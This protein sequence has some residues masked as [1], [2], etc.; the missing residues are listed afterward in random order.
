GAAAAEGRAF[1][2]Y[3]AVVLIVAAR[4][5]VAVGGTRFGARMLLP[6]AA[7][8]GALPRPVEFGT[9]F[10]GTVEFRP[11]AKRAVAFWTILA[12]TRETRTLGAAAVL[13]RLVEARF[14]KAGLVEIARA[15]ARGARIAPGMIGRGRIAL[16]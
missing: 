13:A 16:L 6:V 12:R 10:A 3:L 15:F 7:A 4:A 14:V 2:K 11:L 5:L 8:L 9:V 1:C